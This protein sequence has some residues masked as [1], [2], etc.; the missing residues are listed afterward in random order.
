MNQDRAIIRRLIE[1]AQETADGGSADA[2]H[3]ALIRITEYLSSL[4]GDPA[5]AKQ[6][7]LFEKMCRV[8]DLYACGEAD[9]DELHS[10]VVDF[11]DSVKAT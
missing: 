11:T 8:A 1:D 10:A 4:L 5:A 9:G 6:Q 7:E 3:D 2:E